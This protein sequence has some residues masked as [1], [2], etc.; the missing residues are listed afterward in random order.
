[1]EDWEEEEGFG[2]DMWRDD[3]R[4]G[5]IDRLEMIVVTA[6]AAALLPAGRCGAL[7][8]CSRMLRGPLRP[9]SAGRAEMVGRGYEIDM[10][11]Y[12]AA[13]S[14]CEAGGQRET[15]LQLYAIADAQVGCA[16]A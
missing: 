5:A 3:H 1:M 13:I 10:A 11:T 4:S 2:G 14:A 15:A 6:R 16:P 7:L 9:L 8:E 12:D